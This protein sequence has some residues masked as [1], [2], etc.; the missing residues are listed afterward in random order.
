MSWYEVTRWSN[1]GV[2]K[3]FSSSDKALLPVILLRVGQQLSADTNITVKMKD[4]FS[5]FPP[6]QLSTFVAFIVIFV[7][8]GVLDRDLEC[9]CDPQLD[10]C[11]EY[12][13][14]PF[15]ILFVLQL[16]K[17]KTCHRVCQYTCCH[18][19]NCCCIKDCKLLVV[20]LYDLGKAAFFGLLWVV[21]VYIDGDWFVCC[22][23]YKSD[24]YPDLACKD[25]EK[26][27]TLEEQKVIAELKSRSLVSFCFYKLWVCVSYDVT[28]KIS[29]VKQVCFLQVTWWW[30]HRLDKINIF[31]LR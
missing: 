1:D 7:Y 13:A 18:R 6:K 4:F 26:N 30:R 3:Q 23:N 12:M 14:L 9:S 25:K 21:A 11:R 16:W 17:N 29:R 2:W 10:Y 20:V 31:I 22:R 19:G 5:N 8:N 15:C 24:K 28:L 27:I